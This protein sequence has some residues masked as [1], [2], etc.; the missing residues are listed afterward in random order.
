MI[1]SGIGTDIVEISRIKEALSRRGDRFAERILTND[2]FKQY[3]DK[4]DKPRFLAKRFAAKEAAAKALGTGFRQG[5]SLK[6]IEVS[7]DELGKPNLS[8]YLRGKSLC[9]EQRVASSHLTISDE[10]QYAVAFVILTCT[11]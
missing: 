4:L 11:E 7:N 9:Q 1:I 2:E 8:F 10:R 6:H 3:M 5:L